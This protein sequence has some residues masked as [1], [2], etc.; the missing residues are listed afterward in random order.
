[1][2][3]LGLATYA[4]T[5][6]CSIVSEMNSWSLKQRRA[7]EVRTNGAVLDVVC[8]RSTLR[9]TIGSV[10]SARCESG[11]TYSFDPSGAH[12]CRLPAVRE[13]HALRGTFDRVFESLRSPP[14]HEVGCTS[15]IGA[16]LGDG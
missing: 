1:M 16:F 12:A 15:T 6:T 10:G 4:T 7:V 2:L 9:R 5:G 14:S 3:L 11:P 8:F 13:W